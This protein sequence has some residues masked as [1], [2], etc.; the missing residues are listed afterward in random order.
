MILVSARD[1]APIKADDAANQTASNGAMKRLKLQPPLDDRSEG[2]KLRHA[3][4]VSLSKKPS[5]AFSE[6]LRRGGTNP[7]G[8]LICKHF[9][10]GQKILKE[11]S[12]K[13]LRNPLVIK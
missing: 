6:I 7:V 8:T 2:A 11:F 9:N 4:A 10:L 13:R 12:Q 1:A 3:D 5:I